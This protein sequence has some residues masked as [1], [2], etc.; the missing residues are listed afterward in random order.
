MWYL[1]LDESGDLGFDFVN[2]KPS[3]FFTVCILATSQRESFLKIRQAVRKTIRRK[4]NKP[5]GNKIQELKGTNTTLGVKRYFYRQI[6]DTTFGL[7]SITLNKRRVY[8]RLTYEKERVYNFIAHKVLEQIPFE[9]ASI[10]VQLVV[11][12]SKAKPEIIEFN[13]YIFQQLEGRLD[14]KVSMNIDH[15]ISHQDAVLQAVDIFTWG[16]FQ[17]YERKTEEWYQ[18]FKEKVIFDEMYL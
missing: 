1:Y 14:P 4:L 9:K 18:V 2:K 13:N 5:K 17:K 11:D 15:L 6:K 10:R 3:R 12:K 8:E 7:Y 16:V